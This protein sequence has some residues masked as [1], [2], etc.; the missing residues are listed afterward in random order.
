[1]PEHVIATGKASC[2]RS[3]GGAG[4]AGHPPFG[5]RYHVRLLSSYD[6]LTNPCIG[7]CHPR[8]LRHDIVRTGLTVR[9]EPGGLRA[10]LHLCRRS[11][12]E[13]PTPSRGLRRGYVPGG[14]LG[15]LGHPGRTLGSQPRASCFLGSERP[16]GPPVRLPGVPRRLGRG[17]V[18]GARARARG[19]VVRRLSIA[20]LA[21]LL[22]VYV[23]FFFWATIKKQDPEISN[24][25]RSHCARARVCVVW[26]R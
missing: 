13:K 26:R 19:L 9:P 18:H 4:G 20:T 25:L 5:E 23:P 15:A 3:S 7:T 17:Q 22:P 21:A 24:L 6:Q 10:P 14:A 12:D 11:P 2:N 16:G 1:M 8:I